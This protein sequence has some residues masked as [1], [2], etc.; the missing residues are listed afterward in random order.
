[1]HIYSESCVC[2]SVKTYLNTVEKD[3]NWT[4]EFILTYQLTVTCVTEIYSYLWSCAHGHFKQKPKFT[5]FARILL[6]QNVHPRC[7]TPQNTSLSAYNSI[8]YF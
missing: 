2:E 4:E 3:N 7:G 8:L 5:N 6:L 1:M